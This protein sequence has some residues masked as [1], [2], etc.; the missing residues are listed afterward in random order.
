MSKILE[1]GT[2]EG[3]KGKLWQGCRQ[4]ASPKKLQWT[5]DFVC[6]DAH[7]TDRLSETSETISGGRS[8]DSAVLRG[9]NEV[10]C[11]KVL[12]QQCHIHRHHRHIQVGQSQVQRSQ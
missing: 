12:G 9:S 5:K 11:E 7:Q 6:R 2:A 4:D 10:V 8:R 1:S 3:L